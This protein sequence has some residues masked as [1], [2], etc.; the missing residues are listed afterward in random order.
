MVEKRQSL[1]E[2]AKNNRAK[3]GIVAWLE[4]IPEWEECCKGWESGLTRTQVRSWLIEE[5]GYLPTDATVSR[6][7]HLSKTRPRGTSA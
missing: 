7:A 3:P 2:F 6:M 5:C 4:T 1:T